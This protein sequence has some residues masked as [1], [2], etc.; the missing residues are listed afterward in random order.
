M[1]VTL[2]ATGMKQVKSAVAVKPSMPQPENAV[3]QPPKAVPLPAQKATH[4]NTT[5]EAEVNLDILKR[6]D[7]AADV[8]PYPQKEIRSQVRPLT[9]EIPPFLKNRDRQ[10]R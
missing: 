1:V 3:P 7:S 9:L 4:Q 10:D 5:P 6:V 8:Q 2:I